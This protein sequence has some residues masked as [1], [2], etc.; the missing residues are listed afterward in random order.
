MGSLEG[1]KVLPIA[2]R[3]NKTKADRTNEGL[4]LLNKKVGLLYIYKKIQ[5][6]DGETM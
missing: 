2:S 4:P 5:I 3:R 1:K 6:K